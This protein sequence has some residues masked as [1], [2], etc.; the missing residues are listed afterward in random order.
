ML[1]AIAVVLAAAA[2]IGVAAISYVVAWRVTRPGVH[3]YWDE[4][5]FTPA[6]MGVR[7]EVVQFT[8]GDGLRLTAWY[9]PQEQARAIIVMGSGYRDRKTSLLPIA[10]GLWRRG[11]AVFLVDFRNQGDSMMDAVQTMGWREIG[12]MRAAVEEAARR[13]PGARIGALGWSMGAAV[14]IFAAAR[15]QR[16]AAL[17]ADSAYADQAGVLAANFSDATRL[18]TFP[19]VPLAELFI[20]MRAGYWPRRVRPEDEIAALAPRPLLLIH[21]ERDDMCPVENARRLYARARE[22]KEIWLL[23]QAKHV[24]AYFA[25]PARYI[26]RVADFFAKN[27]T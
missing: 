27:L 13:A 20:R 7:Y 6:D 19:F 15:D 8:A 22:P 10:A 16:I 4:Y 3:T 21:G 11:F 2:L 25:D 17:V 24:G 12:D 1:L 26:E 14:S 5:T 9:M 23:P 18:P